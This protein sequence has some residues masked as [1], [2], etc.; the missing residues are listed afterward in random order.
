MPDLNGQTRNDSDEALL[1]KID[2]CLL[3]AKDTGL[4]I[5]PGDRTVDGD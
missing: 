5:S 1:L 4:P 2:V 3:R